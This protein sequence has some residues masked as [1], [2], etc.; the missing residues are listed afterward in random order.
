MPADH[1]VRSLQIHYIILDTTTDWN[2][3]DSPIQW[4]WHLYVLNM[5]VVIMAMVMV[6]VIMMM[7]EDAD[8]DAD[9]DD[10]GR[11]WL[12][13]RVRISK[14]VAL[15]TQ[16]D[17]YSTIRKDGTMWIK[18]S[19]WCQGKKNVCE[20]SSGVCLLMWQLVK[21]W[22]TKKQGRV[23]LARVK[24]CKMMFA[25]NV[26]SARKVMEKQQT[27]R[28]CQPSSGVGLWSDV[29]LWSNLWSHGE[30]YQKPRAC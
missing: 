10:D 29:T 15:C 26:K 14:C 23:S 11:C 21:S 28:V 3:N 13:Q 18:V 8:N 17:D 30:A 7:M 4:R 20:P 24:A 9:E 27:T 22:R 5:M 6:V 16:F 2:T 1:T 12:W 19:V 25:C